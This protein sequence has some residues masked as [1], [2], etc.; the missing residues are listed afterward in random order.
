[1]S[2]LEE[3]L[4]RILESQNRTEIQLN[5]IQKEVLFI[6]S[7]VHDIKKSVY[8]IE[9]HQEESIMSMLVHIKKQGENIH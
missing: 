7:D 6:K 4:K 5:N 1:V 3:L 9:E 8:R 2:T